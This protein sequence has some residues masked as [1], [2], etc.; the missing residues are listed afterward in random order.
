MDIG[1]IKELGLYYIVVELTESKTAA[2]G[3]ESGAVL[4]VT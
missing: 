3:D 1:K 2:S 4:S